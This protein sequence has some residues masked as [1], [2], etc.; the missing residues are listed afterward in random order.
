MNAE[1]WLSGEFISAGAILVTLSAFGLSWGNLQ[2]V[3]SV[4]GL[5]CFYLFLINQMLWQGEWI[6]I[7]ISFPLF[8][9]ILIF[10]T[11]FMQIVHFIDSLGARK[12]ILLLSPLYLLYALYLFGLVQFTDPVLSILK[13]VGS[14]IVLAGILLF[15]ERMVR[16]VYTSRPL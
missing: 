11:R 13:A 1:F 14:A 9:L 5:F 16:R 12:A 6:G 10:K 8:L 7:A 4:I 15:I 3:V 2:R